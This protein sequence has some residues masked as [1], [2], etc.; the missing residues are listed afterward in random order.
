MDHLLADLL[1]ALVQLD[2]VAMERIV[3]L[4]SPLATKLLTSATGLGS[5]T[6][7]LVFVGLCYLA[8]WDEEYRHALVALALSGAVVGTLMLTIQR[9]YPPQPVCLTEGSE[10]VASSFPSGHAAA[11]TVYAMTARRSDVLPAGVVAAL[12]SAV[13]FS[14]V[15]LGTHYL[16]DTVVGVAIGI[17]AF[18]LAER[19]LAR[20]DVG[21]LER[22]IRE[23][24]ERGGNP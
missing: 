15:Y 2:A 3:A 16:T 22:R 11:V 23:A 20:A 8:G 6:A 18:L 13:A 1:D 21:A 12:A 17:A 7:A 19:L 24:A 14:R 10:T 4:R 5:A 9:P